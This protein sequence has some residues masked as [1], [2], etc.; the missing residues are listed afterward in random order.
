ML[1]KFLIN[2][3]KEIAPKIKLTALDYGQAL[4]NVVKIHPHFLCNPGEKGAYNHS[5]NSSQSI[6]FQA[7]NLLPRGNHQ[8]I[9]MQ[10]KYQEKTS[11]QR[12]K[13]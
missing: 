6:S 2:L 8:H 5:C 4:Q 1:K 12:R 13:F 10:S 3:Q 7:H 11:Q 9:K